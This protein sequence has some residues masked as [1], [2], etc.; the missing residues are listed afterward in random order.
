MA[1]K[2]RRKKELGK[3]VRL[4]DG[5]SAKLEGFDL[6][7]TGA[8]GTVRKCLRHP[9]IKI[10]IEG[11]KIAVLPKL[12]KTKRQKTLI[13]SFASHIKSMIDGVSRGH[14]Y[15]LRICSGHF[16]MNVAVQGNQLVIKNFLGEKV[17]RK[18]DVRPGASVKVE[19]QDITVE[20]SSLEAASQMAA[21]IEKASRLK[22]RDMRVFQ[23]GIF[24]TAKDGREIA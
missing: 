21:D 13:G 12:Q 19:G 22:N 23:D 8:R 3:A 24:I 9:T 5:I 4:P 7:V 16:P 2:Q 15:R 20:S 6:L 18:V 14:V 17:P 11:D 1:I 10:E